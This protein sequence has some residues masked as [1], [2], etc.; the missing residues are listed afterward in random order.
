MQALHKKMSMIYMEKFTRFFPDNSV[1]EDWIQTWGEELHNLT[2]E[3]IK[4]GLTV[5]ARDNPWPPTMAEFRACCKAAPVPYKPMLQ[6]P[7]HGHSPNAEACM[8]K[9]RE[10]LSKPKKPGTWWAQEIL[11]QA[12]IGK[13]VSH[14]ALE[15]A[16]SVLQ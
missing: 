16:N 6:A 13:R 1:V 14:R 8:A 5:L 15:L 3:Q 7:K 9:I 2:G 12:A 4:H 10:M 11:D